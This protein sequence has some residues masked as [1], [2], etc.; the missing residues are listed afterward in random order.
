MWFKFTSKIV[1]NLHYNLRIFLDVAHVFEKHFCLK[2]HIDQ[3]NVLYFNNPFL[4]H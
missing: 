4:Q 1:S 3:R 2:V